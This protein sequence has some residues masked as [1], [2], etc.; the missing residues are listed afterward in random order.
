MRQTIIAFLAGL[1]FAA[2]LAVGGMT[3]PLKVLSFLDV[4]GHWDPS[5]AFVM[6]GAILVYGPLY[7][8]VTHRPSPLLAEGFHLPTRQD[9][10]APLVLGSV[11]FGVGW[12]MAGFCPGPALVSTMSL[13]FDALVLAGSM[14]VGMAGFAAWGSIR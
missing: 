11:L 1:L 12:G 10:D 9:I 8:V 6:G 5:L 3:N 14:L 13:G 2:G 7:R 4:F